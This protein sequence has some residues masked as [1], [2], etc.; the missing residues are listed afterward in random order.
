MTPDL[1]ARR[2]SARPDRPADGNCVAPIGFPSH[3]AISRLADQVLQL[4]LPGLWEGNTPAPPGSGPGMLPAHHGPEAGVERQLRNFEIELHA[5]LVRCFAA[6]GEPQ[7]ERRA[8][9]VTAAMLL[10]LPE[11]REALWLDA[12][13]AFN[14]DPSVHSVAEAI[15]CLPGLAAIA[16][17]R[18][19]HALYILGAPVLPRLLTEVGHARTGC[20]I[21]PGARI[22]RSFFI[23]HATGVVIGETATIG[24]NV[25]IYHGVTLGA[26]SFDRDQSGALRRGTK[27][28]PDIEDDVTIYAHATILGGDTR[29]GAGSIIGSN[30]WLTRSVPPRSVAFITG[31]H[32]IIQPRETAGGDWQI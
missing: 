3:A 25:R 17:Q 13:A 10:A 12:Q 27:R 29:I 16:V 18:F 24:R 22:G 11:L 31:A 2:L 26:K 5:A 15:H 1:V 20:D 8:S 19:A 9:I 14:A 32:V 23:D 6:T 30:V 7:P 4:L 28:H 21:H